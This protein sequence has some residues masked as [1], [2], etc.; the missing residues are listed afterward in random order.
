MTSASAQRLYLLPEARAVELHLD[1]RNRAGLRWLLGG[2][3][4]AGSIAAIAFAAAGL[5]RELALTAVGLALVPALMVALRSRLFAGSVPMLAVS[6]LLLEFGLA[7]LLAGEVRPVAL[8]AALVFPAL[9]LLL[10]LPVGHLLMLFGVFAG[11]G[12]WAVVQL[13]ALAA[14]ERPAAPGPGLALAVLAVVLPAAL[15]T[16][17]A[18]A[19]GRRERRRFVKG[20]RREGPRERERVRMR[21]EL[22]DARKIQ[23][24]MLPTTAPDLPWLDLASVSLPATEVGGDYFDYLALPGGGLA[25][26]VGDVAGHGVGSGL[27]LSGV[28]SGLYLLR[29]SLASPGEAVARLNAMVRDSAGGRRMLV[30]LLVAV[31]DP[32]GGRVAA[33][34]AGHPPLILRSRGGGIAELGGGAPPLG[35]RLPAAYDEQ[36]A[37][38]GAGDLLVLYS[39]GFTEARNLAGEPFGGERLCREVE[40]L[41]ALPRALDVR[42]G[43]LHALSRFKGDAVQAD[44]LTLLVARVRR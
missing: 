14:A 25:L 16:L 17:A 36:R 39:D 4:V 12:V 1:A 41:A 29:E 42:D 22:T 3:L 32:A 18:G 23:L 2:F 27:V 9:P 15:L 24:S 20:W 6:F 40:R 44:D 31:L 21:D 19:L 13:G 33:V 43:L 30:T 38:L 37:P 35:T 26:V 11:T 8:L 5:G 34:S 10:R 28:R 7:V